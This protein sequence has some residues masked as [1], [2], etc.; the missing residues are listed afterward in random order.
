MHDVR[1]DDSPSHSH[2]GAELPESNGLLRID[3]EWK[4]KGGVGTTRLGS[5]PKNQRAGKAE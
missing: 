3:H 1:V 5:A 4:D 2:V